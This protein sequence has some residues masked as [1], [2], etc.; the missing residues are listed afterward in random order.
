MCIRTL[1]VEDEPWG[2]TPYFYDLGR[3][4][5]ECILAKSGDQAIKK[6]K[7][8]HFDLLSIDIMFQ[9]GE[10]FGGDILPIK[11]GLRLLEMIRKGEIEN[12]DPNIEVIVLT[13]VIDHEIEDQIR[14]LGVSAYLKK[15]VEFSEVIETFCK[16]T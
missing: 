14:K 9:P 2:V 10:S 13:A 15:P 16:L 7:T 1:F 3:K 4:G 11:A 5:F 12:C 8:Q 6:L